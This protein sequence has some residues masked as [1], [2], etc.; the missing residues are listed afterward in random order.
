MRRID[1]QRQ[2]YQAALKRAAEDKRRRER[3]AIDRGF[4]RLDARP[5]EVSA[6]EALREMKA[7][8]AEIL[9]QMAAKG[10]ES[11]AVKF[12]VTER[13]HNGKIKSFKVDRG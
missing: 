10:G 2:E 5:G 9:E 1:R 3:E 7:M 8:L 6:S 13:D 4:R 12:V 11:G